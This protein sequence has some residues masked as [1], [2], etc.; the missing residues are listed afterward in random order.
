MTVKIKDFQC[1]KLAIGDCMSGECE[2]TGLVCE[3]MIRYR[4]VRFF[5]NGSKDWIREGFTLQEAKEWCSNSDS[6]K[7]LEWFDGYEVE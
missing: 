2:A 4:I 5:Y 7:A 3:D 1:P 6:H